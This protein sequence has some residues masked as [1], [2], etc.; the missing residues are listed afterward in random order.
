MNLFIIFI[1]V[2][3]FIMVSIMVSK[4]KCSLDIDQEIKRLH[5]FEIMFSDAFSCEQRDQLNK[6]YEY[7]AQVTRNMPRTDLRIVIV[8]P[9][10]YI[11]MN[12]H[13]Y[14][15]ASVEKQIKD[16]NIA[17]AYRV[18]GV[19]VRDPAETMQI[20][21]GYPNE[22][23]P[24]LLGCM[25]SHIR[26]IRIA[27]DRNDDI[28]LIVED[29]VHFGLL[30]YIDFSLPDLVK[31]APPDWEI[32]SLHTPNCNLQS[33]REYDS[34]IRLLYRDSVPTS[35]RC[36]STCAYLITRS[37]MH[38]ILNVVT[39]DSVFPEHIRI[40]P[41]SPGYPISGV[42]DGYLYDILRTYYV[43][44][45]IVYPYWP[46]IVLNINGHSDSII[47]DLKQGWRVENPPKLIGIPDVQKI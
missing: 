46:D 1:I 14:R 29:D 25:A 3:V 37:A 8:Y 42:A 31:V 10:Y 18:V 40:S 21:W 45:S 34:K 28:A 15:R 6:Y 22:N 47:D 7:I 26:A 24:G 13:K 27:Y 41:L 35:K 20:E 12:R 39:P 30:G 11:N 2:I 36:W 33:N 32:I 38:R 16:Y 4:S 19:D 23:T 43:S 44:P 5:N 9:V 17:N